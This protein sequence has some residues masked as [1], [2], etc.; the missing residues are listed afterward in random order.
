M[1]LLENWLITHTHTNKTMYGGSILPKNRIACLNEITHFGVCLIH[2]AKNMLEV[3]YIFNLR[4]RIQRSVWNTKQFWVPDTKNLNIG[5]Y[6]ILFPKYFGS[7]RTGFKLVTCL[8]M[9]PLKLLKFNL[10]LFSLFRVIGE[11]HF[12]STANWI[13]IALTHAWLAFCSVILK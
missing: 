4:V 5:Q 9:S 1:L 2:P 13:M 8:W 12:C 11:M 3:W 10:E 7:P 6:P